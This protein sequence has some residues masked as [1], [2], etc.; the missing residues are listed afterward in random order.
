MGH[1][2]CFDSKTV[3]KAI[4]GVKFLERSEDAALSRVPE[5]AI[6]IAETVDDGKEHSSNRGLSSI[7]LSSYHGDATYLDGGFLHFS[8]VFDLD[9]H[10]ANLLAS[11]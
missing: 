7:V 2:C 3:V 5:R 1:V 6:D 10:C 4:D 9:E 8:D 11:P